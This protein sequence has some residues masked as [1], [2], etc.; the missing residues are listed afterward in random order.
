M[1]LAPGAIEDPSFLE[2][3][4]AGVQPASK[5]ERSKRPEPIEA[6]IPE[7]RKKKRGSWDTN[8]KDDD[9]IGPT[10]TV[11]GPKPPSSLLKRS[12]TLPGVRRIEPAA[13]PRLLPAPK[14]LLAGPKGTLVGASPFEPHQ[15]MRLPRSI[16]PAEDPDERP[17]SPEMAAELDDAA[18]PELEQDLEPDPVPSP[19]SAAIGVL[20]F[21]VG[22][23]IGAVASKGLQLL[24]D[25]P[26]LLAAAAVI[27][28]SNVVRLDAEPPGSAVVVAEEDGRILGATPLWF[29]LAPE[30][31]VSVLVTAPDHEPVR[32]ILPERGHLRVVLE[33]RG[34]ER[35][36][37]LVNLHVP[38]NVPVESVAS[39]IEETPSGF[40]VPGSAVIRAVGELRGAW[41]LRCP[42]LGGEGVLALPGR[43][44]EKEVELRVSNPPDLEV[45]I[46]GEVGGTSPMR[47]RVLSGF[48]L[49]RVESAKGG[50][51]ER[52][53]PVFGDVEI[54]FPYP[55]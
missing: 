33:P 7:M 25:D 26:N 29:Q 44:L 27:P 2:A 19:R 48:K 16:D 30:Q 46:D 8:P 55:N 32:V 11:L 41:L 31:Q 52:W 49:I 20:T 51:T 15:I 24:E 23:L 50:G 42:S 18:Q 6:A 22:L 12:T 13:L 1:V 21:I 40:T 28:G 39:T 9:N 34:R 5:R 17:T 3:P 45:S 14:G 4:T 10:G 36:S 38:Q 43:Q 53:V 47:K 37:C 35:E 54:E